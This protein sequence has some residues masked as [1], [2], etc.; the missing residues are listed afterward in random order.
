MFRKI[1]EFS[2]N[3]ANGIKES[4]KRKYKR[5][6]SPKRTGETVSWDMINPELREYLHDIYH[7]NTQ[8]EE[9]RNFYRYVRKGNIHSLNRTISQN[10]ESLIP[11]V[12]FTERLI[13]QV[14]HAARKTSNKFG[15]DCEVSGVATG[16]KRTSGIYLDQFH[17]FHDQTCDS[18]ET[19]ASGTGIMQTYFDLRK[20]KLEP[21]S[22]AHSHNSMK[23]FHSRTDKVLLKEGAK[24][25]PDFMN[26]ELGRILVPL[27]VFYNFVFNHNTAIKCGKRDQPHVRVSLQK[28]YITE[29]GTWAFDKDVTIIEPKWKMIPYKRLDMINGY[30]SKEDKDRLEK[31]IDERIRW[32]N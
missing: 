19:K 22:Q 8:K 18:V 24:E 27:H 32:K 4:Y 31:E 29:Q 11:E 21:Y 7:K 2:R 25:S 1:K 15:K 16:K 20:R 6:Y 17:I 23:T 28:P 10:L 12:K 26:K 13:N 5:S 9:V 3:I 30:L 14:R